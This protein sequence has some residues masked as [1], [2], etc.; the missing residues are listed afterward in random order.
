[1]ALLA[2][3]TRST[4]VLVA[5]DERLPFWTQWRIDLVGFGMSHALPGGGAASSAF[6]VR[7]MVERGVSAS[8]ALALT[9]VQV[10]L[11]VVGLTSVW[12]LGALMSVPRTGVTATTV[13]LLATT[14][15]AAVL[16]E[17]VARRGAPT[18]SRLTPRPARMV[19]GVV[20]RRWREVIVSAVVQ[21]TESLRD[22]RV[23]RRGVAWAV[24]NWL[25]DATCLWV[26]LRAAGASVP[27]ELVIAAYGVVNAVA[28]LPITP[29]GIGIVEGLLIP[30]LVAAGASSAAA[31]LGVLMWRLLQYWLPLPVAGL[32]WVSLDLGRRRAQAQP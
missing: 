8:T 17:T 11:S 15:A 30:A 21:G 10:A 31:V 14:A 4:Q 25:L 24:A 22:A 2:A 29:G 28:M 1:V 7:L 20:P 18:P 13:A 12:L 16:L 19:R 9:V 26:C 3:Y 5:P 23:S 6:R 32:C 27:I